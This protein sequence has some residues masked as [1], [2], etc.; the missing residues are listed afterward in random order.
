MLEPHSL[1]N[2]RYCVNLILI[3]VAKLSF[4]HPHQGDH[5]TGQMDMDIFGVCGDLV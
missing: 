2:G 1:E 4:L 3:P 5:N